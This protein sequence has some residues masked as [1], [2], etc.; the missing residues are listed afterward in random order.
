MLTSHCLD[1]GRGQYLSSF[2]ATS[3]ILQE[4]VIVDVPTI[5]RAT[6]VIREWCYPLYEEQLLLL[7]AKVY[8]RNQRVD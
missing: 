6:D 1:E 4:R 5:S 3:M 8:F 2:V 7:P